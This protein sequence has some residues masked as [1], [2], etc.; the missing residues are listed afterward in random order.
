[1]TASSTRAL[2]EKYYAAF[3]A[4][5]WETFLSLL[6]DDVVHDLNQ[7]AR[8][9]GKEAFRGFMARMAKSYGEQL[10]DIAVMVNEDGTRASA[11]YVVLGT[12]LSADE[13]LPAAKGQKYRLAGGAFFEVRGDRIARVTNYYNLEDWLRQVR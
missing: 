1:M 13:G 6:T 5:D 9:E 12:Y 7:G 4:G 11:E 3:N 10:V 8:E 2:L